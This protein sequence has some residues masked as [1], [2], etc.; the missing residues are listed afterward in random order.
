MAWE[1]EAGEGGDVK[2]LWVALSSDA[3]LPYNVPM[4]R[5]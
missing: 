3:I 5:I 2:K 4:P 1:K